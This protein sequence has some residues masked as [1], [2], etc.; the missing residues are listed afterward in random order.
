MKVRSLYKCRAREACICDL[1]T[2]C[3]TYLISEHQIATTSKTHLKV[4]KV[5]WPEADPDQLV[6]HPLL[7]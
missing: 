6:E 2:A 3:K 7:H 1:S 5:A 4:M